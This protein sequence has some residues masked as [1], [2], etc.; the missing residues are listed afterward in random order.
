MLRLLDLIFSGGHDPKKE[1]LEL[2]AGI[3]NLSEQLIKWDESEIELL[4]L[5]QVERNISKRF[6]NT[7]SGI[8]DSIYHEHMVAYAY[9]EFSGFAKRKALYATTKTHEFFYLIKDDSIQIYVDQFFLGYMNSQGLLY[10][11][12]KKRLIARINDIDKSI[13]PI[14]VGDKEI[15]A[16]VDPIDNDKFNPRAFEYINSKISHPDFLITMAIVIYI[17]VDKTKEIKKL[18]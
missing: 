3:E 2:R 8:F 4:S 7:V 16:L 15:A 9:R 14:I 1:I 6:A 13:K 5:N 12:N 18:K 11:K 10:G 17:L